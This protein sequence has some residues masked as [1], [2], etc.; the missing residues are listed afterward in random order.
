M[1]ALYRDWLGWKQL[2]DLDAKSFRNHED[3]MVRDAAC[4]GFN[5]RQSGSRDIQTQYLAARRESL[6][7]HVGTLA[8]L[9][10]A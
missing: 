3:F 2:P 5:L 8:Q 10:D 9:P 1:I 7:R 4:Q 6:L